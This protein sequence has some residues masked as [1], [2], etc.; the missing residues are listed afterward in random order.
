MASTRPRT[1]RAAA[2]TAAAPPAAP[3]SAPVAGDTLSRP[4]TLPGVTLEAGLYAL[5]L[6]VSLLVRFWR[7][8]QL[9]LSPAE[10][11]T[12]MA[13]LEVARGAQ[14]PSDAGAL[15]GFG[16]A[17]VLAVAGAT[18]GLARAIPAL[19]GGFA[20][21]TM[22]WARPLIGRAPAAL[23]AI[24]L[25][26]SPLL[27]DRARAVHS[28]AIA[29]TVCLAL[30]WAVFDYARARRPERLYASA[31]LLALALTAGLGA[32]SALLALLL[33][34][35]FALFDLARRSRLPADLDQALAAI[36]PANGHR[37]DPLPD[38]QSHSPV[39][40]E[41]LRAIGFFAGTLLVVATG[42][43]TNPGGV[44]A[45]LFAPLG[46]WF[47]APVQPDSLPL[48][49]APLTL[50]AYEPLILVLGLTG[51]VGAWRSRRAKHRFL[52]LWAGLGVLAAPFAPERSADLLA[53]AAAPGAVLAALVLHRLIVRTLAAP[54][55]DYLVAL[56]V[57]AWGFSLVVLGF[58]HI[59]QVDPIAVRYVAPVLAAVVGV[60]GSEPAAELL[61]WLL[62]LVLL[63][64][65]VVYLFRRTERTHR[66]SIGAAAATILLAWTIHSSWNLAYQVVGNPAELPRD[67]QT[68][69]DVR[70]L[71][72]D[73]D[74]IRQVLTINRKDKTLVLDEILRYPLAWYLRD[75]DTRVEPNPAGGPAMLLLPVDAEAPTGRYAAQRYQVV[76]S[77]QLQFETLA[78]FW[79]WL[80]YRESPGLLA[81]GDA[82][83]YVRAQ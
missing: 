36:A 8:D 48:W 40:N 45:G 55:A 70:N 67:P 74:S 30:A 44:A 76:S 18:D 77:S 9:P 35:L 71:A 7:L 28:G 43:L 14:L 2:V 16:T 81:F 54:I 73:V 5:M 46:A 17:L 57:L 59:S 47:A 83:L 49:T 39:R 1:R 32:V 37:P 53:S 82:V 29:A 24:L 61:I 20:P 15:L 50:V 3:S 42:A 72:D 66:A 38:A 27:V 78:Q 22:L 23:A 34:G 31:V 21:L 4:L 51:A 33:I 26:F 80:V 52:V 11:R 13:A 19:V 75:R 65:G 6:A 69:I 64:G 60:E 63:A 79:R 56:L 10:S 12:A 41:V 62:P 58:G 25:T 68:S